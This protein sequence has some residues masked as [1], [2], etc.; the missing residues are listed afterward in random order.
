MLVHS[1]DDDVDSLGRN[2]VHISQHLA[3]AVA[4]GY[5]VA[6]VG[7]ESDFIQHFGNHGLQTLVECRAH[8]LA[9]FAGQILIY[10]GLHALQR[11]AVP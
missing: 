9:A 1:V 5:V 4:D 10:A 11:D 3:A 2:L 8:G 7:E 6:V